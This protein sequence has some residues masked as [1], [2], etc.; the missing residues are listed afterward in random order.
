MSQILRANSSE[1][2]FLLIRHYTKNL[3]NYYEVL[4]VSQNATQKQIRDAFI[5]LSKQKHPDK[6]HLDSHSEFVKINEAYTVLSKH[7]SRQQYD[8]G[9]RDTSKSYYTHRPTPSRGPFRYP[10]YQEFS[11]ERQDYQTYEKIRR[12]RREAYERARAEYEKNFRRRPETPEEAFRTHVFLILIVFGAIS[13][14]TIFLSSL[15][16]NS[17]KRKQM[18]N[19]MEYNALREKV[20]TR[21][22]IENY[23]YIVNEMNESNSKA[24]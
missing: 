22:E 13:F 16:F 23:E 20:K 2:L 18:K 17:M 19:S 1:L 8:S 24:K 9:L 4:N 15:Q 10:T 14:H 3:P 5:K 12:E 11:R 21:S 6:T 7:S